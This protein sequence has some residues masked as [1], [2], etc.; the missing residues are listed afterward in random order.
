M[1]PRLILT[2]IAGLLFLP[3]PRLAAHD[4]P[5]DVTVRAFVRPEGDRLHLVVRVPLVAMR[6]VLFPTRG[7][8]YLD[9]GNLDQRLRDAATLWIANGVTLFE[10][11]QP[12]PAPRVMAARVSLPSDRS[13][14]TYEEARAHITGPPLPPDTLLL[15]DQAQFDVLL[16]YQIGSDQSAFSIRSEFSRFGLRVLTVLRFLPPGGAVRPFEFRGDPGLVRLDPRWHQ[17]ALRFI[18]LGFDHILDGVDHLLFL[19]C[20]VIPF[21][22]VR[23]LVLIVTAFTVAHSITLMASALDLAPTGLWFPPFIETMIA[24]SIVYMGLEN[25]VLAARTTEGDA[26][27]RLRRR[28]IITFAFGLVHGFGFS[29]ALRETMQFAG[30]HLLTSLV[31]FNTGVELGQLAVLALMV[32]AISL[33]FRHV[34]AERVGTIILSALVVH[35]A[36]HWMID[37]GVEWLQFE[38]PSADPASL[39][40]VVRWLLVAW[41]AAGVV[42]FVRKKRRDARQLTTDT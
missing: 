1:T 18:G 3:M 37:R 2:L 30:S 19:A 26:A 15:L 24:V 14:G 12:L 41:I 36:W 11:D 21:R 5:S 29:F 42:W 16:E 27:A 22:R 25:I 34:V 7:P 9:L 23:P 33:L 8:G 40:G 32:P 4:I 13:F 10:E 31:A 38:G 20:L 35:Q 6:D 39:A 17:A 28:W